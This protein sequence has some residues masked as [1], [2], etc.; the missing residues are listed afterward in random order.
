MPVLGIC[1][2][3]Q[4]LNVAF[5]GRLLQRVAGHDGEQRDGRWSSARHSI[6][7]SPGSKLAA[8]LGMGGFFRVNSL[9][10]QA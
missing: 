4:L 5:G 3:M 7:V 2:G 1:R 10:R 6:Y 8:I 9:H